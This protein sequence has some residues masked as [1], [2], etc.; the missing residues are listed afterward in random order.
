MLSHKKPSLETL[1]EAST[2]F[3]NLQRRNKESKTR[4]QTVKKIPDKRSLAI[5]ETT[6][7]KEKKSDRRS[8]RKDKT[9][10]C[11]PRDAIV[12]GLTQWNSHLKGKKHQRK[13]K[14]I[15]IPG[16]KFVI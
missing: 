6:R 9:I 7:R 11:K 10:H 13:I 12:I 5:Q 8:T 1:F 4:K 3:E 16:V 14:N 2:A 15:D